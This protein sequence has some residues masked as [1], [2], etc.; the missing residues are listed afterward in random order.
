[1][2]ENHE[3]KEHSGFVKFVYNVFGHNIGYKL[4]AVGLGLVVWLITVGL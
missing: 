1:M 4:L 3:K 2:E